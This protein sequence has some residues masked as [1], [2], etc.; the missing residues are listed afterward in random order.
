MNN[1]TEKIISTSVWIIIAISI[2]SICSVYIYKFFCSSANGNKY[3]EFNSNS[4]I[5]SIDVNYQL[6]GS[7]GYVKVQNIDNSN[8][9]INNTA[10]VI[11]NAVKITSER[12][13]LKNATITFNYNKEKINDE[14]ANKLGIVLY[15]TDR[16]RMELVNSNVDVNKGS[17]SFS[18]STFGEYAVVNTD[19]W[20][21]SWLE[22]QL[23]IRNANNT[24]YFDI[25]FAMDRSGSMDGSKIKLSQ[26]STYDFITSLYDQDVFSLI[27]FDDN[28]DT[29]INSQTYGNSDLRTIKNITE[30]VT[31]WG[32]TSIDSALSES[33]YVLDRPEYSDK[34]KMIILLSDGNSTINDLYLQKAIEKNIKIITIGFGSDANEALLKNIAYTTGGQYY[35]ADETNITEIFNLVRN[36]YIG[37]DMSEDTDGD[38]LPDIV[39]RLGMRNQYGNIIVTNPY[40]Y[41]TDG[42]GISDGEEMG[43]VISDENISDLDKTKGMTRYVYF[44]MKSDP[45]R[46]NNKDNLNLS[47]KYTEGVF[48]ITF[49]TELKEYDLTHKF[50]YSDNFFNK[51]SSEYNNDL[52]IMSL[53]MSMAAFSSKASDDYWTSDDPYT[54]SHQTVMREYNISKAYN[55]LR[56]EDAKYYNYNINLNDSSD[57][58]AY[59]F[60]HKDIIDDSGNKNTLIAVVVRGGG[61]GNEWTSN[62]KVGTGPYHEGFNNASWELISSLY[63]YVSQLEKNNM[64]QGNIKF[65]IT[66]Y[67]RGAAVANI[68][69]SRLIS[70]YDKNNVYAYCFAVPQW[71]NNNTD[72]SLKNI[73]TS[74]IYNVINPGDVVT[75]I[76]L[77]EWGY[78][79]LGTDIILSKETNTQNNIK[80][81]YSYFENIAG[82]GSNSQIINTVN[83][84]TLVSEINN[85]IYHLSTTQ[86]IYNSKYQKYIMDMSDVIF[87]KTNNASSILSNFKIKYGIDGENALKRVQ[88]YSYVPSI[89][90]TYMDE[91]FCVAAA[92][93]DMNGIDVDKTVDEIL[94]VANLSTFSDES[95]SNITA[96]HNPEV[97]LSW[98]Y[99]CK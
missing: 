86:D 65:W 10:G 28:A 26:N 16:G 76:P 33:I 85:V 80:N 19:S 14:T 56:F 99:V 88:M 68:I 81:V 41:D 23:I 93:A 61:Y 94:N 7:G 13:T 44:D 58:T 54:D 24:E 21:S 42:D 27:T 38:G 62:F 39:E 79:R 84:T 64:I 6:D 72:T 35:K 48:P 97:Y 34:R 87:S 78:T 95:L 17:I 9:P 82:T 11:S 30:S 32:G 98:L 12:K 89:I 60:A 71:L 50:Y 20:Y 69:A 57:K 15:N 75:N 5:I 67:S 40:N 66:G 51:S 96:A 52:S 2:I 70:I 43:S 92:L 53:A 63:D 22:S 37:V 1:K 3:I 45:T 46:N 29:L 18:T 55:M 73:D 47:G 36:E 8:T 90:E 31:A 4:N 59:S 83:Q 74:S 91:F 49:R 77:T 25:V